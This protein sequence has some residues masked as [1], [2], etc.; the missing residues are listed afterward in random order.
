MAGFI[1]RRLIQMIPLTI[2]VSFIVFAIVNLVPGSP[3]SSNQFNPRMTQEDRDRIK[4]QMGLDRPWQERY[5]I[6]ASHAIRGD[7]GISM[8]NSTPVTDR[9]LGVLPNTL[10]LS[11]VSL[12]VAMMIAIPIGVY[13]A[14]KQNSWFDH[15]STIGS[16]AFYAV[17]TF[18]LGLLLIILFAV[19]FK[20]WGLPSL[21]IGG[22][23][24]LRG[25]SGPLDR[26]RHLILPVLA[27]SLVQV[28]AW[29]R[30]I[31]SSMLEVIRQDY[32]RTARAKGLKDRPIYYSHAFRNALIPLITLVGL[33]LPDLFAGAFLI[34]TIFAWNGMGR[35]TIQATQ[36]SDY[37]LIMGATLFFAILTMLGNLI[38][39]V[40]YGILDPRIRLN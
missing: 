4:A 15:T 36:R 22:M 18:W 27:L 11:G 10:L 24:D 9:L 5:F 6:W 2:G 39:D 29:S 31:R 25:N 1:I 23:Q 33:S 19:K 40:M 14:V 7:L 17:P 32:I 13:A 30:Y 26:I 8:Q 16:V 28:A 37:T 38:A 20:E 3:V 12:I 35:L 34:E 21:P